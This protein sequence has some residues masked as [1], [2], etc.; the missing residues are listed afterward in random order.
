MDNW[1]EIEPLIQLIHTTA[2]VLGVYVTLSGIRL[3]WMMHNR[4]NRQNNLNTLMIALGQFRRQLSGDKPDV[5]AIQA[6]CDEL[7]PAIQVS[8]GHLP[9]EFSREYEALQTH[10]RLWLDLRNEEHRIKN[11]LLPAKDQ[12][13][14]MVQRIERINLMCTHELIHISNYRPGFV[15]LGRVHTTIPTA[16]AQ[17]VPRTHNRTHPDHMI[18]ERQRSTTGYFDSS[19]SN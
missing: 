2:A 5:G 14:G 1:N 3:N 12:L 15:W 17:R 18:P 16:K 9:T 13:V 19:H 8:L 6:A 7:H 4:I 10:I 11:T